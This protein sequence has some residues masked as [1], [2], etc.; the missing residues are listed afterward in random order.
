M[1]LFF[2]GAFVLT[3]PLFLFFI[4]HWASLLSVTAPPGGPYSSSCTGEPLQRFIKFQ[5]GIAHAP[6]FVLGQTAKICIPISG[7][8]QDGVC[9]L[10]DLAGFAQICVGGF[11]P[12]G[13]AVQLGQSHHEDAGGLGQLMQCNGNFCNGCVAVPAAA[14]MDQLQIVHKDDVCLHAQSLRFDPCDALARRR[15]DIQRPVFHACQTVKLAQGQRFI[16]DR[17]EGRVQLVCDQAGFQRSRVGLKAEIAHPLARLS[18]TRHQ[19]KAQGCFACAGSAANHEIVAWNKVQ[20]FVQ[21]GQAGADVLRLFAQMPDVI[22][23]QIAHALEVALFGVGVQRL[24]HLLVQVRQIGKGGRGIRSPERKALKAAF[25]GVLQDDARPLFHAVAGQPDAF[26][27]TSSHAGH[28]WLFLVRIARHDLENIQLTVLDPEPLHSG[29]GRLQLRP[30]VLDAE[31]WQGIRC[32]LIIQQQRADQY[33]LH[34]HH[35]SSQ[36]RPPYG[37]AGCAAVWPH[38]FRFR[39]QLRAAAFQSFILALPT[40]QPLAVYRSMNFSASA[41]ADVGGSP[42][43][44]KYAPTSS[45]LGGEN[46]VADVPLFLLLLLFSFLSALFAGVELH[47]LQGCIFFMVAI[48]APII[49]SRARRRAQSGI[50]VCGPSVYRL[51][52]LAEQPIIH[53]FIQNSHYSPLAQLEIIR[54]VTGGAIKTGLLILRKAPDQGIDQEFVAFEIVVRHHP[55]L[56]HNISICSHPVCLSSLKRQVIAVVDHC[57]IVVLGILRRRLTEM[58]ARRGC[59][60]AIIRRLCAGALGTGKIDVVGHDSKRG[61]VVT[62]F[63]LIVAGFD[64]AIDG[65]QTALG[66]IPAHKLSLRPP[67]HNVDEICLPLLALPDETAVTGNAEPADIHTCRG[68]AEFRVR[69]KTAHDSYN[70]KH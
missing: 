51:R 10:L 24:S 15:P 48:F 49:L 19:L 33:A 17:R 34:I 68:R 25:S 44:R 42:R 55:R 66:E 46:R 26:A 5:P 11:G 38:S 16:F 31:F 54:D 35:R 32:K 63:V 47:F 60:A 39:S 61:A 43:S 41:W 52:P 3:E 30:K 65:D 7:Q 2:L 56:Y 4:G 58:I 64:A 53:Q 12:R 22:I 23:Q 20:I 27:L 45:A 67:C 9:V 69:H 70:I 29:K 40:S 21:L 37:P 50:P 28:Q 1:Q 8:Q 36:V 14:L 59:F 57:K 18:H 62:V 13:V 6:L